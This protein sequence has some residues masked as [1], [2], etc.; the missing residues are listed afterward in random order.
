MPTFGGTASIAVD[1]L[2]GADQA[3]LLQTTAEKTII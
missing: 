3:E 1:V 2:G